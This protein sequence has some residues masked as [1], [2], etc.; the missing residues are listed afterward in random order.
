V[1]FV[2]GDGSFYTTIALSKTNLIGYAVRLQFNIGQHSRDFELL[3][4]FIKYLN[5]GSVK[6]KAKLP[7]CLF[8]VLSFEDQL[9]NIIPFFEKYPLVGA[10]Q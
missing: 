5:Y 6:L 4:S 9:N 2:N 10:K 1:G 7:V 3:S 8:T